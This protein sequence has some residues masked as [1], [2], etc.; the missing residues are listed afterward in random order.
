M[1]PL[2]VVA[3]PQK[4]W[5][6]KSAILFKHCSTL[7]QGGTYSLI[8]LRAKNE[9]IFKKNIYFDLIQIKNSFAHFRKLKSN[10]KQKIV[11]NFILDIV[12]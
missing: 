4:I 1:L 2:S 10:I 5:T 7:L 3:G 11:S 8:F 6:G 9:E 12:L